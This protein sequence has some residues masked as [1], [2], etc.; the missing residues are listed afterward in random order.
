VPDLT[1]D[2]PQPIAAES[3]N[4]VTSHK[5]VV[6]ALLKY[7]G[8][9]DG[10][11]GLYVRFGLGA[12]NIG[13]NEQQLNPAAVVPVVEIGLQKFKSETNISVD[14]AKVNPKREKPSHRPRSHK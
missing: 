11:W 1:T 2:T 6:E 3:Q 12:T 8:I 13:Q 9:H 5:Q 4:I 10:V 14:A 7:H